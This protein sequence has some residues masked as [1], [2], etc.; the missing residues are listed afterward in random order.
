M[1]S[2]F[3][4]V[5]SA[6]WGVIVALLLV[7]IVVFAVSKDKKRW[8]ARMLANGALCIA[9]STVLSFIT[10]YKMPQ[11]GSITLASML[12]MFLF[13]YAYGVG[14]GM[15]AQPMVLCSSFREVCIS[16]ILW[17]CYLI[18]RWLLP[19]WVWRV[20]PTSSPINGA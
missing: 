7:G 13:A 14:P 8:T 5:S 10:L 3:A 18:I 12:P 11:G 15:L 19:C 9:L 2:E 6:T 20:F 17:S 1:F 16:F 4:K